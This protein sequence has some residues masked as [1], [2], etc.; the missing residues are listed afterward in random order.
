MKP[1][2]LL[3]LLPLSGCLS[4]LP[5]DHDPVLAGAY[6]DTK[7]EINKLSCEDKNND[8]WNKAIRYAA[9]VK[10]YSI[11]RDDPQKQTAEGIEEN[12]NKALKTENEKVCGH[13][14]KLTDSRM[15]ALETAWSGR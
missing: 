12:L 15:K 1:L 14:L 4:L 11:L 8:Q 7:I 2:L 6:V 3:L 9:F 5:R 10:E 13:W